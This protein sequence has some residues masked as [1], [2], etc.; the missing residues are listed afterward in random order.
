LV[1]TETSETIKGGSEK[2][3]QPNTNLGWGD[4]DDEINEIA[5]TKDNE[6]HS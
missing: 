5:R 6:F 1:I 2:E 4:D 3:E